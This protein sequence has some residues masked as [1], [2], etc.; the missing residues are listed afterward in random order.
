MACGGHPPGF[1]ESVVEKGSEIERILAKEYIDE[2]IVGFLNEED[3][4]ELREYLTERLPHCEIK[5]LAGINY[6]DDESSTNY[7]LRVRK[8]GVKTW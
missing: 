2:T 4:A 8:R 5:T 7:S 6:R 3:T 1:S